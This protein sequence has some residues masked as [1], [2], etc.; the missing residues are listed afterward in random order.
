[1]LFFSGKVTRLVVWN[2]G[3]VQGLLRLIRH[4]HRRSGHRVRQTVMDSIEQHLRKIHVYGVERVLTFLDCSGHRLTDSESECECFVDKKVDE[5]SGI[6]TWTI[7]INKSICLSEELQVSAHTVCVSKE[8]RIH[9]PIEH[10]TW[11]HSYVMQY[12]G[13]LKKPANIKHRN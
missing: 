2:T 8:F 13:K 4:E 6:E 1:M 12:N 3:C 11:Q 10:A 7:Y 9:S 5:D